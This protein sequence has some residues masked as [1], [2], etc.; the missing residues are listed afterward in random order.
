MLTLNI[1]EWIANILILG[2]AAIM[3]LIAI[4]GCMLIIMT[5]IDRYKKFKI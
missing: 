5:L 4:F 1:A 2:I 3:W